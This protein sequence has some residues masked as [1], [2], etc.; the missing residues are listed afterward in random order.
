MR[1]ASCFLSHQKEFRSRKKLH[2][3]LFPH[4]IALAE[5]ECLCE[6]QRTDLD[7]DTLYTSYAFFRNYPSVP[8]SANL[9]NMIRNH[10]WYER[11][12]CAQFSLLLSFVIRI[13]ALL[14]PLVLAMRRNVI[15]L[16]LWAE[17]DLQDL[18]T[19][20]ISTSR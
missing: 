6:V 19:L 15:S 10:L 8:C 17:T 4:L 18:Q 20:E 12:K 7:E 13:A 2:S 14:A 3:N 16:Q 9:Q 11:S 5:V 1:K